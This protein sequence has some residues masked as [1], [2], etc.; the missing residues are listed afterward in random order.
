M[1]MLATRLTLTLGA[2]RV[3]T[4][5]LASS[6]PAAQA[7]SLSTAPSLEERIKADIAGSTVVIYSKT[8]CPF[9]RKTKALFEQLDVSYTAIELN[10][11][12]EGQELQAALAA[13]TGQRTVPNVFINGQHLGG[14]D[15]TIAP[16][17]SHAHAHS[18]GLFATDTQQAAASGKLKEMLAATESC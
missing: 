6:R 2:L 12:D 11:V 15:G 1:L 9:C 3:V 10:E 4:P 16:L 8:H 13:F 5:V 7:R 18:C 14:N 17:P